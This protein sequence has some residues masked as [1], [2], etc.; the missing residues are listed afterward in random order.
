MSDLLIVLI[1]WLWAGEGRGPVGPTGA[2]I[3]RH[4]GPIVVHGTVRPFEPVRRHL[5]RGRP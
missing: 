4:P 5:F 1:L 3:I 2:I